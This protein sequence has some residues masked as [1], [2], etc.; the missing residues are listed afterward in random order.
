M[1]MVGIPYSEKALIATAGGGTPYGASHVAGPDGSRPVSED[2]IR[3]ARALGQRIAS[4][5]QKLRA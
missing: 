5:A 4:I 2:E 3:I 1:V